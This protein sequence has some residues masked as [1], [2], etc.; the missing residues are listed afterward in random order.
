MQI[1]IVAVLVSLA[2]GAVSAQTSPMP[3]ERFATAT[4]AEKKAVLVDIIR[5]EYRDSGDAIARIIEVG[6]IDP[7]EFVRETALAAVISNAAAE[8]FTKGKLD[9]EKLAMQRQAMQRLRSHVVSTLDDTSERVRIQAIGALA[10]LDFNVPAGRVQLS[11][12]TERILVV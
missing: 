4:S 10:S 7:D 8:R 1:Q 2:Q 12:L 3:P 11:P 5:H 9:T 6:I